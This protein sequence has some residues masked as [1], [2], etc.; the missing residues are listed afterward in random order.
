LY[1]NIFPRLKTKT[2]SE[3]KNLQ[4][5]YINLIKNICGN[6]PIINSKVIKK[7]NKNSYK[8]TINTDLIESL[9]S[10]CKYNNPELT[11]FKLDIIKQFTNITPELEKKNIFYDDEDDK[12]NNYMFNKI[13]FK[14]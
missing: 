4:L 12:I 14:T 3:I 13:N 10:L 9:I 6:L 1:Q 11:N 5:I 7:N 8:Y 2:Y